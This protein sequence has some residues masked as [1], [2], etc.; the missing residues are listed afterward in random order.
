MSKSN[1][2]TTGHN[3]P[4]GQGGGSS[5]TSNNNQSFM[6][7]SSRIVSFVVDNHPTFLQSHHDQASPALRTPAN[8]VSTSNQDNKSYEDQNTFSQIANIETNQQLPHK[9]EMAL[10]CVICGKDTVSHCPCSP[11]NAYCSSEHQQL[12]WDQGHWQTHDQQMQQTLNAQKAQKLQNQ[13]SNIRDR[14]VRVNANRVHKQNIHDES[15]DDKQGGDHD[16]DQDQILPQDYYSASNSNNGGGN[17]KYLPNKGQRQDKNNR[18]QNDIDEELKQSQRSQQQ[19]KRKSQNEDSKR[20]HR[21]NPSLS[22]RFA[23]DESLKTDSDQEL[24]NSDSEEVNGA[25]DSQRKQITFANDQRKKKHTAPELRDQNIDEE[26][27]RDAKQGVNKMRQSQPDPNLEHATTATFKRFETQLNP[28]YLNNNEKSHSSN[29]GDALSHHN[30]QSQQ[31]QQPMKWNEKHKFYQINL[32]QKGEARWVQVLIL[33]AK[34]DYYSATINAEE[35]FKLRKMTIE[36]NK[37]K[38][39]NNSQTLGL[40]DIYGLVSEGLLLAKCKILRS[41]VSKV[42][43]L[44]N[45]CE[46]YLSEMKVSI[47]DIKKQI[48]EAK[49]EKADNKS[50]AGDDRSS[51][52]TKKQSA[53][54]NRLGNSN[55]PTFADY[56]WMLSAYATIAAFYNAIGNQVR[57]ELAYVKYV[58]WIEKFFGKDSLEASNCYFLV[59]LYYFEQEQYHKSLACFIKALYSRS[60][61]L[62]GENHPAC[63]DCYLNMAILYKKLQ[64]PIK[65]L[66]AFEHALQ[67]KRECIGTQSLPVAKI[68]E[69]LG[70]YHLERSNYKQSYQAFQECY[71]IRKK[72]LRKPDHE[73]VQKI[74][75]LLLYLSKNIEKEIKER[76]AKKYS[77]AVNTSPSKQPLSSA[78]L[79]EFGDKVKNIFQQQL[80]DHLGDEFNLDRDIMNSSIVQGNSIASK[81][82]GD[83]FSKQQTSGNGVNQFINMRDKN[84]QNKKVDDSK[85]NDWQHDQEFETAITNYAKIQSSKIQD[86]KDQSPTRQA[87]K[88]DRK[89]VIMNSMQNRF[90]FAAQ[91]QSQK[92]IEDED[93]DVERLISRGFDNYLNVVKTQL[94]EKVAPYLIAFLLSLSDKQLSSLSKCQ[95]NS[96]LSTPL[97][98]PNEFKE[99]LNPFQLNLFTKSQIWKINRSKYLSQLSPQNQIQLS[100]IIQ[101][102]L[103]N[104]TQYRQQI[105]KDHR[106]LQLIQEI[107]EFQQT[108]NDNQKLILQNA[109]KNEILLKYFFVSVSVDQLL[110]FEKFVIAQAKDAEYDEV[111]KDLAQQMPFQIRGGKNNLNGKSRDKSGIMSINNNDPLVKILDYKQDMCTIIDTIQSVDVFRSIDIDLP[112]NY[113]NNAQFTQIQRL[114]KIRSELEKSSPDLRETQNL[115]KRFII[116]L[117]VKE[118]YEFSNLNPFLLNEEELM[119][120]IDE[121]L[122]EEQELE[123]Q[124]QDNGKVGDGMMLDLD[125]MV[126]SSS[127]EDNSFDEGVNLHDDGKS[128]NTNQRD[129]TYK[130]ADDQQFL[131][132]PNGGNSQNAMFGLNAKAFN[133]IRNNNQ[134]IKNG[135]RKSLMSMDL[136]RIANDLS[137]RA[138]DPYG[139]NQSYGQAAQLNMIKEHS[140][141]G[142]RPKHGHNES[143]SEES[144]EDSEDEDDMKSNFQKLQQQQQYD[145]AGYYQ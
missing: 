104:K 71:E 89:S 26:L 115:L 6:P 56:K 23:D 86:D 82:I 35:M 142:S 38:D 131:S 19:Q 10:Y 126:E 1:K 15:F 3:N 103:A 80:Q 45:E 48:Q 143:Q 127:S 13:N 99:I 132:V 72:I 123:Q 69:E 96:Q 64:V 62:G 33:L 88:N 122:L 55:I 108:L 9:Q 94:F 135:A 73:D 31:Q 42:E 75:C 144:D 145:Y 20:R 21:K 102:D 44:L 140:R 119:K 113:L 106:F 141:R 85:E 136:D 65:A 77:S 139:Q 110:V 40:R 24:A 128:N 39:Y 11:E 137:A 50:V 100:S 17:G 27:R 134:K 57:C 81:V 22:K 5:S 111:L 2:S 91:Q 78:K 70:K 14:E 117:D 129:K 92:P 112:D 37:K 79:M 114:T 109:L 105:Q 43:E 107:P 41:D 58:Q 125:R 101:P 29:Q 34:Q 90:S 87:N 66:S 4:N 124:R 130:S 49:K 46:Y 7:R 51:A 16:G 30:L 60:R 116:D 12:H 52:Y 53:P 74:S 18:H 84:V 121:I 63:A 93:D 28:S 133:F 98:I 76:E 61:E 54:R 95:L 97:Y 32:T 47:K 68:L 25:N 138:L 83:I 8:N 120:L 67:I 118:A 36:E 59:A